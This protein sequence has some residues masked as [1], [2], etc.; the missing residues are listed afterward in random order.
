MD[1][2]IV[3]VARLDEL[4][5]LPVVHVHPKDRVVHS[6]IP[7]VVVQECDDLAGGS[8]PPK[9]VAFIRPLLEPAEEVDTSDTTKVLINRLLILHAAVH[10]RVEIH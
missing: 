2:A 10:V 3:E 7:V 6:K 1:L 4:L 5:K 9:L 8:V